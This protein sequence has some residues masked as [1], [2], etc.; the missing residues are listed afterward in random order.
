[1]FASLDL[2]ALKGKNVVALMTDSQ[3]VVAAD[4]GHYGPFFHSYGLASAGP[5]ASATVGRRRL[6]MQRSRRSTAGRQ[7]QSR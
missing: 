3:P 7:R 5:I 6:G 4:F 1:M 2:D